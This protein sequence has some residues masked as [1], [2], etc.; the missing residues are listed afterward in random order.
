MMWRTHERGVSNIEYVILLGF[1][2][3]A[4]AFPSS[5][6]SLLADRTRNILCDA[7]KKNLDLNH[8]GKVNWGDA[9][10]GNRLSD[11][12]NAEGTYTELTDFNCDGSNSWFAFEIRNGEGYIDEEG[13]DLLA[14]LEL[15]YSRQ[16]D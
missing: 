9:T 6:L 11:Q 12:A 13:S 4:L 14:G 7:S 8:D 15:Y 10:Y 2:V 3:V 1:L 16:D 5:P